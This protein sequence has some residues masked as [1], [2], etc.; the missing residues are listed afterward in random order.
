MRTNFQEVY[1]ISLHTV[2]PVFIGNGNKITKKEYLFLNQRQSIGV[3][4]I[5]ALYAY[6]RKK[7]L[8]GECEKFLLYE[9]RKDLRGWISD[10]RIPMQDV[11]SFLRYRIPVG[12]LA[13]DRERAKWELFECVKDPYGL[14]YIPGSSLKGM[15]RTIL[16]AGRIAHANAAAQM[17]N[18]VQRAA[19][20]SQSRN[21]YLKR[22]A[23]NL[24]SRAFHSLRRNQ[25]RWSDAVNDELSGMIISDSKPLSIKDMVLCQK[26]D[27]HI[28]GTEKSL[29]VLR[30]C[31]APGT[32]IH[33]QITLDQRSPVSK[34]EIVHAVRSFSELYQNV[35]LDAF[36]DDV[37]ADDMVY[38]GGGS[39][40]VSKTVVYPL[41]GKKEGVKLTQEIFE[42]TRVP[43]SHGHW[44]DDREGVSPHILKCTRIDGKQYQMGLCRLQLE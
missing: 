29:N 25:E 42:K 22:E 32:D 3:I 28:D 2:G 37:L 33:F 7:G 18:E 10:H 36:L 15:L 30:E 12:D 23:G 26:I 43:R 31:I 21:F 19:A 17:K 27:V 6:L 13:L 41:F 20:K 39:G 35:F 14:P 44:K 24:E 38:L 4:R 9:N 40:F 34:E 11:L 16:L 5:E 8:A 1:D